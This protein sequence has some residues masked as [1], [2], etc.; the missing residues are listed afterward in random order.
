MNVGEKQRKTAW[1]DV[2]C[3]VLFCFLKQVLTECFYALSVM[4][5]VE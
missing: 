3:F 2:H 4:L 5:E 1:E